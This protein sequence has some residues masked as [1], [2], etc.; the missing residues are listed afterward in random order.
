MDTEEPNFYPAKYTFVI[1]LLEVFSMLVFERI[2]KLSFPKLTDDK[3]KEIR[4]SN[5]DEANINEAAKD[6]CRNWFLKISV[7]RELMPRIYIQ[8]ALTRNLV[9]LNKEKIKPTLMRLLMTCRGLTDPLIASYCQIYILRIAIEL[10]PKEKMFMKIAFNDFLLNMREGGRFQH[11]SLSF[12]EYMNLFEPYL[13]VIFKFYSQNSTEE[14]F[15]EMLKTYENSSQHAEILKKFIKYFSPQR[16]SDNMLQ[17]NGFI[18]CHNI[19]NRLELYSLLCDVMNKCLPSPNV[20]SILFQRFI[21]DV[22][23]IKEFVP[24]L[25]FTAVL[26]DLISKN[27][28]ST[29]RNQFLIS[30][31]KRFAD[32]FTTIDWTNE[33]KDKEV[34]EKLQEFLEKI[35]STCENISEI[36]ALEPFFQFVTYL[37]STMKKS[38]CKKFLATFGESNQKIDD[39]ILVHTLLSI[40]KNLNDDYGF[41]MTEAEKQEAATLVRK[42][43]KNVNFGKDI[44]QMLNFY[45]EVRAYFGNLPGILELLVDEGLEVAM[46]CRKFSKGRITKQ[47]FSFIQA[48]IS[49]CLISISSIEDKITQF[50]YFI[51]TAQVALLFN[52]TSQAETLCKSAIGLFAE[53]PKK[54]KDL[55]IEDVIESKIKNLISFLIVLPENPENDYLHIFNGLYAGLTSHVKW[56]KRRGLFIRTRILCDCFVYLCVQLQDKLPYHIEN[57]KSNDSLYTE[58]DYKQTIFVRFQEVSEEIIKNIAEI[59][60]FEVPEVEPAIAITK[61]NLNIVNI[62]LNY[63]MTCPMLLNSVN[64]CVEVIKKNIKY[65]R[66]NALR[67]TKFVNMIG[68]IRDT[69]KN[70]K[71]NIKDAGTTKMIDDLALDLGINLS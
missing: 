65:L 67:G 25:N 16:I 70:I 36:M 20:I 63:I 57:I 13:E 50:D 31:L 22:Y 61:I 15:K 8:C 12:D 35:I 28:D 59:N 46:K 1:D 48:S 51:K 27:Y 39:P 6:I 18:E 29:T 58:E 55:P 5:I 53:L 34:F 37:P 71:K 69:L 19:K 62:F 2:K 17:I 44:E 33:G 3:L 54:V 4:E 9:F 52:L 64:T 40:A 7:I 30:I 21:K 42:M 60:S 26:L 45:T 41:S 68:N 24:F 47:I 32:F 43:V 10:L 66:S 23:E 56:S 14:D 11:K 49:F 38:I